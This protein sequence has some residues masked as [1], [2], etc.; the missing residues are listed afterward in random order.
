MLY[1]S[2]QPLGLNK[3]TLHQTRGGS[4]WTVRPQESRSV[5]PLILSLSKDEWKHTG[6]VADDG[7]ERD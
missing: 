5:F 7:S 4:L 6:T 1:S 2:R 3:K